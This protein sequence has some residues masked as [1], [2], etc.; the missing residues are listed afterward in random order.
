[1]TLKHPA[2]APGSVK[3]SWFDSATEVSDPVKLPNSIVSLD[4][5][6]VFNRVCLLASSFLVAAVSFHGYYAK[7][8]FLET[9][10]DAAILGG[11]FVYATFEKMMD[12][13]ASRPYVYRQMLPVAANFL[14]QQVPQGFKDSLLRSSLYRAIAQNMLDSPVAQNPRYFFR[15]LVVYAMV[16]LFTWAAL[17]AM[18]QL[19]LALSLSRP[20]SA[21]TAA[22]F[23]LMMPYLLTISGYMYDYPEL[24]FFAVSVWIALK[25]EWWVLIPAAALATFNKESFLL[26]V[27]ALY[28]LFRV[29]ASRP[30]AMARTGAVAAGSAIV[31][32]LV[33]LRFRANP[34]A[35]IESHYID[36][37][38]F[39]LH[40]AGKLFHG[41]T[42]YGWFLPRA[43][44]PI[45]LTLAAGIVW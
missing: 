42:T 43:F 8:H 13:T 10:P 45:F 3:I 18:Y 32:E 1:M 35:N 16:F 2:F 7:W 36:Q 24:F 30:K 38:L 25:C 28:P 41:E 33:R 34:G 20:V 17:V 12:G 15:Y 5:R 6:G 23:L 19:C 22:I 40:P 29:G 31:Y 26:F 44:N 39:F 4:L 14:D 37:M 11:G 21:L 27:P 9:R